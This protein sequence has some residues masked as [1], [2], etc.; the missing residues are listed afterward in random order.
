MG[1]QIFK[2]WLSTTLNAAVPCFVG[3][4]KKAMTSWCYVEAF[5][6]LTSTKTVTKTCVSKLPNY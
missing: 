6:V 1:I 5:R 3:I 4:A 2:I